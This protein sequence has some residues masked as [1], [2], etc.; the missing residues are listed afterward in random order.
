MALAFSRNA[1][2]R[3]PS[4]R[5]VHVPLAFF[6]G[7]RTF[8]WP[9]CL[10]CTRSP[11]C[12]VNQPPRPQRR[13]VQALQGKR[14][15]VDGFG[16]KKAKFAAGPAISTAIVAARTHKHEPSLDG[17]QKLVNSTLWLFAEPSGRFLEVH[18][19]VTNRAPLISVTVDS[20]ATSSFLRPQRR[21]L[22]F[23]QCSQRL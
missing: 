3:L 9:T 7:L 12:V 6:V 19:I 2:I 10:I 1:L 20:H 5:R 18:K 8:S 13:G 15:F 4:S 17:G 21:G 16:R 14:Y 22:R 11:A 23:F